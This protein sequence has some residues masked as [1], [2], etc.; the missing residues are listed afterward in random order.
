MKQICMIIFSG[1]MLIS[2]GGTSESG[3][4]KAEAIPLFE[5][6]DN[7][8]RPTYIA[9]RLMDR[10][11]GDT[12]ITYVA[13]GLYE[14]DTVGF[15]IEL[16]KEIPAGINGDGSVNEEMGFKTG[17][18]SFIRSGPESDRFTAALA[19][20]WNIDDVARMKTSPRTRS[21]KSTS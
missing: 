9:L 7:P 2:C 10:T 20:L 14:N 19:A 6:A 18:I 13:Q 17:S 8:S 15:H 1:A 5:I 16:D 4:D 21:R 11:D 12:S 3:N